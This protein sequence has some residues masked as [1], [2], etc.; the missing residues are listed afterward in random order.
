M[1]ALAILMLTCLCCH[2]GMQNRQGLGI[3][4]Y[5]LG[6]AVQLWDGKYLTDSSS[7]LLN[8]CTSCTFVAWVYPTQ[9]INYSA[10]IDSRNT[11]L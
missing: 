10:W 9:Y 6:G 11:G 2:A 4:M 3:P 8:G 5:Q 7:T 1:K